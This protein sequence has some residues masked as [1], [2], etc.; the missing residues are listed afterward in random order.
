MQ[1][2]LNIDLAASLKQIYFLF[3]EIFLLVGSLL[4]LITELFNS[5]GRIIVVKMLFLLFIFISFSYSLYS[6][7]PINKFEPILIWKVL[8]LDKSSLIFLFIF[9]LAGF[10]FLF[11]YWRSVTSVELFLVLMMI[12]AGLIV[13]KAVNFIVLI[14]A[15]EILSIGAYSLSA[16]QNNINAK[17][18]AI[19]YIIF[20]GVSTAIFLFGISLLFGLTGT[21]NINNELFSA[22]L[23]DQ[24]GPVLLVIFIFIFVGLFFKIT[25]FPF[26]LWAPDVYQAVPAPVAAF[27]SVVP[28]I[29]VLGFIIKFVLAINLFNIIDIP[30]ENFLAYIVIITMTV[31][32]LVALT[33][34]NAKR[35]MAYSSIAHTGFF[36]MAVVAFHVFA[37]QALLFYAVVYLFMNFG[38]FA[39]LHI[40]EERLQITDIKDFKGIAKSTPL[41]A[42]I[43]VLLMIALTGLPP[44]AGFTAKLFV[45]TAVWEAYQESSMNIIWIMLIVGILNTVVS[46][47]YYLKIPYYMIFKSREEEVNLILVSSFSLN[48]LLVI[49]VLPLLILFIYPDLLMEWINMINFVL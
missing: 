47:F 18:A 22:G 6:S 42:A 4:I 26:H 9:S 24:Q 14:L 45:F 21:L 27:F 13:V 39:L 33:Q 43:M 38:V 19:K 37:Y 12:F 48:F 20:G 23:I 15:I 29:A 25:A 36:L 16:M 10:F 30:W 49:L 31:G 5:K 34:N 2:A 28:K 46:L 44:T 8:L 1:N 11:S 40:Y 3:P 32:N 7:L 41:H 17:E 35:M